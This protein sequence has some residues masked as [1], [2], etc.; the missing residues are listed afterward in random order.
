MTPKI[1]K[2][3][4]EHAAALA[5]IEEIFE[6]KPGTAT[7]NELDLLTM[8][9]ER[10]EKVAFPI[11]LPDPGEAI[12]FRMEQQGLKNKDLIPFIGS[13][14]K[15]SEVLSGQ[16]GLSLTMIRNLVEGLGIP[17]EVLIGKAG[18]E[19]DPKDP[20][21]QG[22]RFPLAVMLK[23][24]WF[25]GFSGTLPEA[26][27]QSADL[28]TAFAAPLGKSALQ[29]VFNRQHVRSKGKTDV[30]G[31]AAWRIRVSSLALRQSLPPYKPGTVTRE[32]LGELTRL[33]Y[34]ERGPKLAEEFLAK[35]GIHLV[36]SAHLPK[37]YLD[38]AAIR[39]PDGSPLVAVTLRHDRLDNFWFTLSHE[40]AHVALH[41]D[42]DDIEAFYD[43]LDKASLDQ[44][45]MDA[46]E[47]AQ[48]GL[49]PTKVWKKAGL[50]RHAPAS[51]VCEFSSD[52]RISPAIAAGRVRFERNNYFLLKD[53]VG[54]GKVRRLFPDWLN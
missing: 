26:K 5:R 49:I 42:R 24:R 48:E 16:R 53:L 38:G 27:A 21:L 37:T 35:S 17:A 47:F 12:R 3:K 40:L 10:F 31:L 51:A 28:L 11:D 29:P 9:V 4:A 39:L 41:L 1:I 23:R 7:G 8:L 22:D 14:S 45:E 34:L 50:H 2:T 25:A 15:V 44:C 18:A 30:Y 32:F 54:T 6:A 33:S 46:D 20:A 36:A 13:P 43:D 19:L 52:L